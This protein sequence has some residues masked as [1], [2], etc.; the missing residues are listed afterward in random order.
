MTFLVIHRCW[1]GTTLVER[2]FHLDND[3]ERFSVHS[4]D[5]LWIQFF[6]YFLKVYVQF[7]PCPFP[8]EC[9][10][11][12]LRREAHWGVVTYPCPCQNFF[13]IVFGI[14]VSIPSSCRLSPFHLSY[15]AVPGPVL[16]VEMLP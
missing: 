1:Q 15:V 5:C 14:P 9:L 11:W 2:T 4:S 7:S 3:I 8:P 10:A 6:K 12:R 13:A 16:L